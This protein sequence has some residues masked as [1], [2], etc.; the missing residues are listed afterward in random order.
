MHN[1]SLSSSEFEL[2]NG[3]ARSL[4]L[5]VSLIVRY[6]YALFQ[7]CGAKRHSQRPPERRRYGR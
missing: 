1:A 6:S 4:I 3:N 2:D 7:S 5:I